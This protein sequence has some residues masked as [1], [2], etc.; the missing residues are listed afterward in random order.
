MRYPCPYLYFSYF[1]HTLPRSLSSNWTVSS[2]TI[3]PWV[4]ISI[5]DRLIDEGVAS[6]YARIIRDGVT[7][8]LLTLILV[9]CY[10]L[11][12]SL[13]CD[14]SVGRDFG[15]GSAVSKSEFA[16]HKSVVNP[17]S[18]RYVTDHRHR[19]PHQVAFL[20]V[21]RREATEGPDDGKCLETNPWIL[22]HTP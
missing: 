10:A 16:H 7:M 6:S 2:R 3:A 4:P 9:F 14:R 15:G 11:Q 19:P 22:E 1:S 8:A 12:C 17:P 5:D 18:S 13:F 20:S 21:C